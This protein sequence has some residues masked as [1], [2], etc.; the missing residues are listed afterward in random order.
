MFSRAPDASIIYISTMPPINNKPVTIPISINIALFS[1]KIDVLF[2]IFSINKTLLDI[3]MEYAA[4]SIKPNGVNR[5]ASGLSELN[6][7]VPA[8]IAANAN[9][10]EYAA[11]SPQTAPNPGINMGKAIVAL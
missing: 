5:T 3:A 10:V 6:S 8:E 4:S 1:V 11:N 2:M 9:P 7:G